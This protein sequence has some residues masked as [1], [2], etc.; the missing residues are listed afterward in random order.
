M[1]RRQMTELNRVILEREERC[2]GCR[3]YIN[4]GALA[5]RSTGGAYYC[6]QCGAAQAAIQQLLG[7]NTR[8]QAQRRARLAVIF[9]LAAVVVVLIVREVV[10]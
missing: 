5:Y 2:F 1:R 9:M 8:M 4:P 6:S 7:E 10:K 3:K